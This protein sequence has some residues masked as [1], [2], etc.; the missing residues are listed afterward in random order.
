MNEDLLQFLSLPEQDL[1]DVYAA[2]ANRLDTL[3]S[4][5]EKD[6]WVCVVLDAL[7]NGLPEGQPKLLFKGGTSLSKAFGLINRFSEDIDLVVHRGDLGFDG[8]R[9]P[10]IEGTLSNNKRKRLFE[11]LKTACSD[12]V[13]GDLRLALAN[14]I[15]GATEGC[16]VVPDEDDADELTLLVE[17]PTLYVASEVPYV[18]PRIKIEAGARSALE[19]NQT[20]TVNPYVDDELP[21]RSFKVGNI[22]VLAAER[23]FWEKLLILH[24][25]YCG[26]RD[27]Q[28]VPSDSNRIS[29]HYYDAAMIVASETGQSALSDFDLLAS[30]R[31]HN[32]VAFRQ[33]WKR[34]EEATPGSVR[35][36]PQTEL[37][38]VIERD[39]A[40]MQ[41]MILGDPPSF[42]W[43]VEQLERAEATIN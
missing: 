36:V 9:D 14:L 40:A 29:R 11:E 28:R 10:T 5:V 34:F 4:Y 41:G 32:L 18:M 33:P 19:P 37:Q 3:P 35:L 17:Y 20:C 12:Y 23:T 27:E 13:R 42:A 2:A 16:R 38:K 7:Y 24:G 26:Y 21:D 1:R 31:E 30:V 39:Y 6:L 8:D 25:T 43:V 22:R 15:E